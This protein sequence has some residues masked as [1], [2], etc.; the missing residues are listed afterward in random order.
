M[1]TRMKQEGKKRKD[2]KTVGRIQTGGILAAL[3]A[4][5]SIFGV[6]VHTEKSVME[7]F[8]KKEVILTT[9]LIPK[10]ME[11]T[12]ENL[13]T[14]TRVATVDSAGV[15]ADAVTDVS[16]LAG[17]MSECDIEPGTLLNH[18][19]FL[20]VDEITRGMREPVLVGIKAED[21]YQAVGGVLRQ[22]DRIHVYTEEEETGEV[23][24]RWDSL[25]VASSFDSAGN[26]VE[27]GTEASTLR[28][29]VYLDRKDVEEFYREITSGNLRIVK[30]CG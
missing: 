3:V 11:L 23:T 30:V 27:P 4:A 21:L 10:G 16:E 28:F 25:Y 20:S 29:N 18:S 19:M 15:S 9:A 1:K 8:E 17:L 7:D 12:E 6:M 5:I 14:Y 13:S 22:G 24:L 2:P 26:R